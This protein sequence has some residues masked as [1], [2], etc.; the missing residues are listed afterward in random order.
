MGTDTRRLV[1]SIRRKPATFEVGKRP[2]AAEK[3]AKQVEVHSGYR[4]SPGKGTV[5]SHHL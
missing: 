5:E 2:E 3:D 4:A 1:G